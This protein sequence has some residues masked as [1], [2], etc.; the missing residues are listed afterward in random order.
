MSGSAPASQPRT[1]AILK[2]ADVW[3]MGVIAYVMMTGRAPFRGR[4]NIAIFESSCSKALAFP[5]KDARYHVKLALSEHFKDFIR[6]ALRKDP[7]QRISISDAI[8]HP[9]VQGVD[10]GDYRLNKDVMHYL[11]QFK[12][13]SRLKKEITR[14]LAANMTSE[15]SKQVLSHFK[16]LDA[17]SDGFL[18]KEELTYLLLDMGYVGHLAGEEAVKMIEH[19]DKNQD[20]VV[21]FDEF[22]QVWYR[23]VLTTT[24][25]YIH[26]VFDVFDDNGDGHIDAEELGQILFPKDDADDDEQGGA[27]G[28]PTSPDEEARLSAAADDQEE[29]GG[30]GQ[31]VI[32]SIKK[33]IG[34]VDKNG[35]GK[36]DFAEFKSAMQEDLEAGKWGMADEGNYG[37]MIGPKITE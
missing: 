33:M 24:A 31:G 1:G 3:S 32:Q 20:G 18:D 11:R 5:E 23:K 19:A 22:K 36:I 34:E 16:R 35:D 4:N 14:V 29:D 12:Y 30:G 37:G 25:Q 26:R 9:W 13:Q 10:A 17:D 21:D 7:A 6:R 8:R 2:A 15:P 28:D 27:A